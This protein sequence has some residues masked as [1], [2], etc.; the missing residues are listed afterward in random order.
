MTNT[1][2]PEALEIAAWLR[3]WFGPDTARASQ[4]VEIQHAKILE[5][6]DQSTQELHAYEL[7]VSNLRAKVEEL[8]AKL[9]ATQPARTDDALRT[10]WRAAGGGFHGPTVETGTMPEAKLLPFLRGLAQ[11]AAQGLDSSG[12]MDAVRVYLDAQDALDN[13]EYHGIHAEPYEKVIARRNYARE[14]LDA[15][16][17]AQ[18]GGCDAI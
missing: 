13:R 3:K 11:P 17:A 16:L 18:G 7:T 15:S 5:L 2:Q 4:L 6:E 10:M 12:L 14:D 9:S 8:E 1:K